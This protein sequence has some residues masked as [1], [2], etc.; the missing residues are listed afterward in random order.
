MAVENINKSC[1]F[2]IISLNLGSLSSKNMLPPKNEGTYAGT[3]KEE[4][5]E[6]NVFDSHKHM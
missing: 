3:K 2:A 4:K 1:I 6:I 5:D